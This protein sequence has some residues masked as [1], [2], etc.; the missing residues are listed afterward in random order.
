M[1]QNK[2]QQLADAIHVEDVDTVR[3]ILDDITDTEVVSTIFPTLIS[4]NFHSTP[5]LCVVLDFVEKMIPRISLQ[6]WVLVIRT[7]ARICTNAEKLVCNQRDELSERLNRIIRTVSEEWIVLEMSSSSSSRSLKYLDRD[8]RHIYTYVCK[9]MSMLMA[10]STLLPKVYYGIL[11]QVAF[12]GGASNHQ[13]P[14][15]AIDIAVMLMLFSRCD[16]MRSEMKRFVNKLCILHRFPFK[17]LSDVIVFLLHAPKSDELAVTARKIDETKS[18]QGLANHGLSDYSFQHQMSSTSLEL[19]VYLIVMPSQRHGL[20][21]YTNQQVYD[22]TKDVQ[23]LAIKIFHAFDSPH[24]KEFI[25]ALIPLTSPL[26]IRDSISAAREKCIEPTSSPNK[27]RRLPRLIESSPGGK[28][29]EHIL[30]S[31]ESVINESSYSPF[32]SILTHD[33]N[34]RHVTAA[35]EVA[36]NAYSLL[37]T[38]R[39]K[40][41]WD[42]VTQ[43]IFFDRSFFLP[44]HTTKYSHAVADFYDCTLIHLHYSILVSTMYDKH[45]SAFYQQL[46]NLTNRLTTMLFSHS[47]FGPLVDISKQRVAGLIL[48]RCLVYQSSLS[49][50]KKNDICN[51]LLRFVELT[52]ERALL[53]PMCIYWIVVFLSSLCF[54]SNNTNDLL[55]SLGTQMGTYEGPLAKVEALRQLKILI[56]RID[57]IK[58]VSDWRCSNNHPLDEKATVLAFLDIPLSLTEAKLRTDKRM[59][60]CVYSLAKQY[61]SLRIQGFINFHH[62]YWWLRFIHAL[63]YS[64]LHIGREASPMEWSPEVWVFA[65]LES[66]SYLDSCL[67]KCSTHFY[68]FN[69]H[70]NKEVVNDQTITHI[71]F[72]ILSLGVLSAVLTNVI[73]H[74]DYLLDAG[75]AYSNRCLRLISL[76]EYQMRKIYALDHFCRGNLQSILE[77]YKETEAN[78]DRCLHQPSFSD[79]LI[80]AKASE[81]VR[82]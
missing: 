18:L 56:N 50:D 26:T 37:L 35:F 70:E 38:L 3:K 80:I 61:D 36:Y 33:E 58:K 52:L 76:A 30:R 51:Y 65:T 6:H 68:Q 28:D 78:D 43:R 81:E 67:D 7:I 71:C 14:W 12:D 4:M 32:R 40:L 59:V 17:Y 24:R 66:P 29:I 62:L 82:P 21:D 48:T 42:D 8:T 22:I 47:A 53:E 19:L 2:S 5:C 15:S 57:V 34:L 49:S 45:T 10:S 16:T 44:Y 39:H 69:S 55:P 25:E 1:T 11:E 63:M 13:R 79:E 75:D 72:S 41:T 60:L 77:A 64:Y 27:K 74:M 54:D 73:N 20:M 31:I 9:R 46:S 23:R